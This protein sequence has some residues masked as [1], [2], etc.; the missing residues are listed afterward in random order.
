MASG[1][2]P[3]VGNAQTFLNDFAINNQ[4]PGMEYGGTENG[5]LYYEDRE[6]N[7]AM[8]RVQNATYNK[9]SQSWV[10]V[11]S[12]LA[13][14][15]TVLL[16]NG[17]TEFITS[18]AGTSPIT[19][20]TV[21][22]SVD[23][24]GNITGNFTGSLSL[25]ALTVPALTTMSSVGV[26]NVKVAG[27]KGD[28][29][30]D[31][32]AAIT[33]AMNAA[34]AVNGTV[35]FPSGT[36]ICNA[37]P[38]VSNVRMLGVSKYD[39]IIQPKSGSGGAFVLNTASLSGISAVRFEQLTFN[40][41]GGTD[42]AIYFY[43]PA[44]YDL[45][46]VDCI[47]ENFSN[48]PVGGLPCVQVGRGTMPT[49]PATRNSYTSL[50]VVFDRCL[51]RNNNCGTREA[52]LFVASGDSVMRNCVFENNTV[53]GA[54][55]VDLYG[56]CDHILIDSC[57]F[58]NNN[59]TNNGVAYDVYFA[60]G[61]HLSAVGCSHRGGNQYSCGY[62]VFCCED[63]VISPSSLDF[64]TNAGAPFVNTVGVD[65]FDAPTFDGN[66]SLYSNTQ[67]VVIRGGGIWNA[68]TGI[69]FPATGSVN[70][71]MSD[72]NIN[73]VMFDN[74]TNAITVGGVSTS[75]LNARVNISNCDVLPGTWTG[76]AV[77]LNGGAQVTMHHL[78][79]GNSASSAYCVALNAQQINPMF[80][81]AFGCDFSAWSGN[82]GKPSIFVTTAGTLR[83]AVGNAGFNPQ[84]NVTVSIG[85]SPWTYTNNSGSDGTMYVSGGTV[86]AI[87]CNG[88]AT[89]V[90][91]GA[92]D[93]P[94][95]ASIT[96]TYSVVPTVKFAAR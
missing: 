27:A 67:G 91:S 51:W 59:G 29:V 17:T 47:F 82:A 13:A 35:F 78:R 77:A 87:T 6:I 21:V 62:R 76:P 58:T 95:G 69:Y 50:Q 1:N 85:A 37:I 8:Y 93:V 79:V 24:N 72:I 66:T 94:V 18:P 19:S 2:Y 20:W 7:G 89:G 14:Y 70:V 60:S 71:A 28:G 3:F 45:A 23:K 68:G 41:N 54:G 52:L 39:S 4:N 33:A 38:P 31:D 75:A 46:F 96:I 80:L 10:L 56:Y 63:V 40:C 43:A 83:R 73:G 81:D 9:V 5:A 90:T 57:V 32:T 86:S 64:P 36:Y 11:N 88:V 30:T 25:S 42:P 22:A 48:I 65:I 49:L 44:F 12:S 15:G 16:S 92:F 53:T 61:T 55:V 84:G 74:C 34:S 26:F